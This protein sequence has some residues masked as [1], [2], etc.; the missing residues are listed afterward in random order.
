MTRRLRPFGTAVILSAALLLAACDSAEERAEGHYQS[1]LE[2]VAAGDVDR[3]L[4]EFR[5]VFNLDPL[6]RDARMT[7]A[8]L[9]LDQGQ[10]REA[11]GQYLVVVEQYPED[12]D[13]RIVLAEMAIRLSDWDEVERHGERAVQLNREDPRSQM[14]NL[15]LRY[16]EAAE[17]GDN[18]LRREIANNMRA[19]VDQLE[20]RR[21]ARQVIIDSLLRDSEFRGALEEIDVALAE[22]GDDP[23]LYRFRL[24]ILNELNDD[25]AFEAQ[26]EELV[27]IYPDDEI[28]ANSLIAW[29]GSRGDI[30]SAEQFMR[31]RVTNATGDGIQER[32]NLIAY[33]RANS[34]DEAALAELET[35]IEQGLNPDLFRSIRAGIDFDAGNRT[36]ALAVL[37]GIVDAAEPSEQTR[38]IKINLARLL[39]AEGNQVGARQRVEEVLAEDSSQVAALKMKAAWLVEDDRADEA[40]VTL[41]TALDQAPRDPEIMTL[42]ARAHLRNGNRGLAGEMLALAVEASSSGV[43]ESIAYATF[44]TGGGN[45]ATA[46]SVLVDAL[47]ASPGNE[48]LLTQLGQLYTRSGDWSRSEQVENTLRRLET[49]TA[50][51]AADGLRVARL[52]GQQRGDEAIDFLRGL[53]TQDGENAAAE[54]AVVRAHIA[55]RDYEAAETFIDAALDENPDRRLIRYLKAVVLNATDRS[56]GAREIYRELL[57]EAPRDEVVWRALYVSHLRDGNIDDARGV[58]EEGLEIIPEAPNLRWALAGEYEREGNIAGAIEIYEA[59]YDRNPNSPVIA[60][61]LASLIATYREDADEIERAYAIARRLRGIAIPAFQD[62]YGWISFRRGDLEAA[63]EHLEPAAAG[64]PQDPIVQYH[65][66]AALAASE[67]HA[68]ALEKFREAL[69]IAGPADT[70]PQFETAR[71]EI[72]RIESILA[73]AVEND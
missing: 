45:D 25:V 8:G 62:T 61:N 49:D 31:D 32:V 22:G 26:L 46:E 28:Y 57:D 1:G 39:M 73:E 54:V 2:L 24:T 6:H 29:Y 37:E 3:A 67:R 63:L 36:E 70:R 10:F 58:L 14:V 65:L 47:R 40:I 34:S 56:A 42:L 52:R 27:R 15:V 4:V 50:A 12:F 44:L 33:L 64:L 55:S 41:R 18:S 72:A 19:I 17:D 23:D 38:R 51:R 66:A 53:A 60:N 43:R 13:A 71:S 35:Y 5:N 21:L 11:Y 48:D 69:A 7:Y 59:L 30:E 20:D 16:R 68:E 9:I